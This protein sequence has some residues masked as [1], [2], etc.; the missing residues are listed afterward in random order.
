MIIKKLNEHLSKEDEYRK[1][2]AMSPT[3]AGQCPRKVY[4]T[5]YNMPKDDF[6]PREKLIF[7]LGDSIHK[8]LQ[9]YFED[10]GIQVKDEYR[11][12]G[13][14]E[15]MP[16]HGYVDSICVINDKVNI[17]EIKSHKEWNYSNKCYL[18]EP[19]NEHVAQIMM[20]MHFTGIKDGIILYENKN[21]CELKEFI[22][23]YNYISA[24]E[25]LCDLVNTW[26]NIKSKVEPKRNTKYNIFSY[27]CKYCKYANHCYRDYLE[28]LEGDF[29]DNLKVLK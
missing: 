21:T 1:K 24:S 10:I 13:K 20:Y 9:K 22:V 12:E 3:D 19:K 11:I 26:S 23:K 29:K 25:I 4:Y 27:P 5:Y 7:S 15:G 17:V 28:E 16:I 14:Y 2:T 18:V 6:T 8:R